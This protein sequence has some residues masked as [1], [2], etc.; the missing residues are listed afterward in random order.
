MVVP[1]RQRAVTVEVARY[2]QIYIG[3]KDVLTKPLSA[4]QWSVRRLIEAYHSI[5]V[6]PYCLMLQQYPEMSEP[7]PNPN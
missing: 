1:I 6:T 7:A 4:G 2:I 3:R 5:I